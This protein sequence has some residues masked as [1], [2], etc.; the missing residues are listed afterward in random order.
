MSFIY[1]S[2]TYDGTNLS[3]KSLQYLLHWCF[4]KKF[5]M[6][7]SDKFPVQNWYVPSSLS[8]SNDAISGSYSVYPA[9][10]ISRTIIFPSD[11]SWVK[12]TKAS[13]LLQT[14]LFLHT[15][16]LLFMYLTKSPSMYSSIEMNSPLFVYRWI[17]FLYSN[18]GPNSISCSFSICSLSW[19][20][21][22]WA[23]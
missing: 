10:W 14:V 5:F 21:K 13:A 6:A 18:V 15:S 23:K 12:W 7:I 4:S 9:P 17:L 8:K 2:L 11:F 20:A 22:L 19:D 16:P 3:P 1:P